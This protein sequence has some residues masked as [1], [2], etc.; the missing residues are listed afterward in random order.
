MSFV[1]RLLFLVLVFASGGA[2]AADDDWHVAKTT[3]QVKFTL[4]RANWSDVHVGDVIPNKAWLST[5]PRG[6]LQLTRGVETISLQPSTLA[7]ITTSGFFSRKTEILQ[8]VGSVDLEIEKRSQPHTTVQTPF[9]AA[10][11]KG[12]SFHV[13][14]GKTKASVSVDRGLVEV[15]SFASGQRSDIG[16]RQSATVDRKQGMSV[17]GQVEPSIVSVPRSAARI[18]AIG[19]V[20]LSEA[21]TTAHRVSAGEAAPDKKS[22]NV[23]GKSSS[24]GKA[25]SSSG[26]ASGNGNSGHN[27]GGNGKGNNGNGNGNGG[28]SGNGNSGGGNGNGNGGSGNG[29]GNGNGGNG[30]SGNGG[31]NGN[32]GGGNGNNGN[33]NGNGGASGNGNSGNG[34][35]GRGNNK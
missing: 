7:S 32:N 1:F 9:L 14:V 3:N 25:G 17:S 28:A 11:V 20:K 16:P 31:G 29:N 19:Q 26:N 33:G 21:P 12:T 5:G 22:D 35:G 23:G 6:R 13:T 34:S 24:N 18:P 4:D 10:V 27:A 8:Q 30:G 2:Q 15:T